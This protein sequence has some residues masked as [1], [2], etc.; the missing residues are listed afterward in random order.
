MTTDSIPSTTS[1][2]KTITQQDITYLA[3]DSTGL[4]VALSGGHATSD[5]N[6]AIPGLDTSSLGQ[7]LFSFLLS[8]LDL[9][10]LTTTAQFVRTELVPGLVLGA[11]MLWDVAFGHG[12]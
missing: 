3:L 5:T 4:V 12:C 10:F 2:K 11:A 8:N 7:V 9:L 1:I 6:T